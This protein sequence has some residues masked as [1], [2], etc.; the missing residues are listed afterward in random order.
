MIESPMLLTR[1]SHCCLAIAPPL[2]ATYTRR[3][4]RFH[5]VPTPRGKHVRKLMNSPLIAHP[6]RRSFA[7]PRRA[8][9]STS[10]FYASSP[11]TYRHSPRYSPL[12]RMLQP[13][14]DHIRDTP[15]FPTVEFHAPLPGTHTRV[16]RHSPPTHYLLQ[17]S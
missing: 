1:R 13:T 5:T 10:V 6:I 8:P 4:P 15:S 16:S 14:S 7:L 11:G 12:T 3:S 9:R 2:L 17:F